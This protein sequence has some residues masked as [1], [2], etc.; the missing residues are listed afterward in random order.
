MFCFAGWSGDNLSGGVVMTN[1]TVKMDEQ[2]SQRSQEYW[3]GTAELRWLV[4]PRTSTY[5]P[6][7]QQAWRSNHGGLDWKDIPTVVGGERT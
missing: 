7:L 3:S 5:A 1:L 2:A 6:R 4:P